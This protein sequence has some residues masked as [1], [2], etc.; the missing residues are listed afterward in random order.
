M[1]SYSMGFIELDE[2]K[3]IP[4]INEDKLIRRAK[5][6]NVEVLRERLLNKEM[7][8]FVLDIILQLNGY[9]SAISN[10]DDDEI[11][12]IKEE[13]SVECAAKDTDE[14]ELLISFDIAK[15]NG[16]YGIEDSFYLK[17]TDI[18]RI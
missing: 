4:V 2:E 17:V 10:R 5:G 11:E 18:K 8:S 13:G 9:E 3:G 6:K 14:A 15:N 7:Y 16:P 12:E 1:Q